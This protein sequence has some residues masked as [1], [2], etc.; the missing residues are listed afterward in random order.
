MSSARDFEKLRGTAEQKLTLE[1]RKLGKLCAK[2]APNTRTVSNL[3][4][5]VDRCFDIIE[6]EIRQRDKKATKRRAK[7]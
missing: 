1:I 5:E 4:A 2:D 7:K 6:K 3:L